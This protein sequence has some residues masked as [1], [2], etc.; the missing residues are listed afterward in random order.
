MHNI[1]K[2]KSKYLSHMIVP[3]EQWP[4][5]K[6]YYYCPN[7]HKVISIP[8][9]GKG[10][11]PHCLEDKLED[12]FT[13]MAKKVATTWELFERT[14]YKKGE[15]LFKQNVNDEHYSLWATAR[16]ALGT[17]GM[18]RA[19]GFELPWDMTDEEVIDRWTYEINKHIDPSTNL[20]QVNPANERINN[21]PHISPNRYVSSA[22]DWSLKYR[23]FEPDAYRMPAGTMTDIDHL[24]S[25]KT[26]LKYIES[27]K[28]VTN[29]YGGGSWVTRAIDNHQDIL[30]AQGKDPNDDMVEFV[31]KWLDETQ[32]P[33]NGEW[34]KFLTTNY[35]PD[36]IANGMFKII[37]S[38]ERQGWDIN[39]KKEIMDFLID[40]RAD[41]E[42]GFPG[43]G[44]SI[45]D[46]MMVILALRK[47]A[48]YYRTEEADQIVANSFLFYIKGKDINL[49]DWDTFWSMAEPAYMMALLLDQPVI[50][51]SP[52][53]NWRKGPILT[54]DVN[55]IITINNNPVYVD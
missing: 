4:R 35:E 31:H 1:K 2:A 49:D 40:E 43:L 11:C 37:V 48:F 55:G 54:R 51:Y 28:G 33:V 18:L 25:E 42:L 53:Y 3:P 9:N 16:T 50:S 32:N 52:T 24:E 10:T 47:H 13:N 27:M 20:L 44:C 26:F 15:W 41:K 39:Y 7:C 22:Y 36:M 38:Y 14:R 8:K 34:L 45:F 29:S 30:K 46:P 12:I 23:I 17:Y 21:G 5:E 6:V 19:L